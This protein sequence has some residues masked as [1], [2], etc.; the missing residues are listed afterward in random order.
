MADITL[1]ISKHQHEI[2]VKALGQF[3]QLSLGQTASE[4]DTA[5]KM[6]AHLSKAYGAN[7]DLVD[8]ISQD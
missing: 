6:F 3:S 5:K 4:Q 2:I 7:I 1:I 8:K